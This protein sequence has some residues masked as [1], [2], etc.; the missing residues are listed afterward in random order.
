M[1]KIICI[2]N[3]WQ[4]YFQIGG[5]IILLLGAPVKSKFD[6]LKSRKNRL[7]CF[8]DFRNPWEPLFVA[9]NIPN[10]FKNLRHIQIFSEIQTIDVK[11]IC[12]ENKVKTRRTEAGEK[13][14]DNKEEGGK[15]GEARLGQD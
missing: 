9:L 14:Q 10:Y 7:S 13:V 12:K 11:Y 2:A 5:G 6:Q 3:M 1:F 15:P 8:P 4:R